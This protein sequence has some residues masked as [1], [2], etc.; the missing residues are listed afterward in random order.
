METR[1]S[2]F[3]T[4]L[5]L[6]PMYPDVSPMNTDLLFLSPAFRRSP[7]PAEIFDQISDNSGRLPTAPAV[8]ASPLAKSIELPSRPTLATSPAVNRHAVDTPHLDFLAEDSNHRRKI[9]LILEQI[10]HQITTLSNKLLTERQVCGELRED[11]ARV[12]EE[13]AAYVDKLHAKI[14]R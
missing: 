5:V 7:E 9:E 6:A 13:W 2:F 8:P 11:L 14:R 12:S 3:L 1:S 10:D 4:K